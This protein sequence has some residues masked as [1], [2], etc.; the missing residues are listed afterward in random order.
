MKALVTNTEV[1]ASAALKLPATHA[2]MTRRGTG[3]KRQD[4]S[5]ISGMIYVYVSSTFE[6]LNPKIRNHYQEE[7]CLLSIRTFPQKR[8][9]NIHP[10]HIRDKLIFRSK[11]EGFRTFEPHKLIPSNHP[12]SCTFYSRKRTFTF[13]RRC[14][15]L[16][17][18]PWWDGI[19]PTS[20]P[21]KVLYTSRK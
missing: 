7:S 16:L 10:Q 8:A 9:P 5:L 13:G 21:R 15:F 12:V 19:N 20:K 4:F 11:V 18:K 3:I 17:R 6:N 14:D 1:F 2:P